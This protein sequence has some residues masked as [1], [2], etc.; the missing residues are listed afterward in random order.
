M[1]NKVKGIAEVSVDSSDTSKIGVDAEV[2][3]ELQDGLFLGGE[4]SYSTPKGLTG[5]AV[6]AH[7]VTGSTQL[8]LKTGNNFDSVHVQLHKKYSDNGEVAANYDMD[9]NTYAP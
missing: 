3:T 4:V 7:Y 2:S 9:L 1:K 5:H 6:G 8:T